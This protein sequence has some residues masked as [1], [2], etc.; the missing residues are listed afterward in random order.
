MKTIKIATVEI[1]QLGQLQ[2]QLQTIEAQYETEKKNIDA[3]YLPQITSLKQQIAY[4]TD[5]IQSSYSDASVIPQQAQQEIAQQTQQEIANQVP[6]V[7]Q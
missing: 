7:A 1:D 5:Y 2:D 6:P 4:L 3:R